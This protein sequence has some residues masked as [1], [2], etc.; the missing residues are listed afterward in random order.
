MFQQEVTIYNVDENT[1]IGFLP[2]VYFCNEIDLYRKDLQRSK[3]NKLWEQNITAE[4]SVLATI[5][6]INL[7]SGKYLNIKK[8]L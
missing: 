8:S 2:R 7:K 5:I 3:R 4:N 1:S 6:I